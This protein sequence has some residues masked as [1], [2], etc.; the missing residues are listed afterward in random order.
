MEKK[1]THNFKVQRLKNGY[2]KVK[3]SPLNEKELRKS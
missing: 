2:S 1:G 3:M